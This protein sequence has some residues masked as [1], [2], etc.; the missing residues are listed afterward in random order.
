[1]CFHVYIK[2]EGISLSSFIWQIKFSVKTNSRRSKK[3]M[4][5]ITWIF[6]VLIGFSWRVVVGDDEGESPIDSIVEEKQSDFYFAGELMTR[7]N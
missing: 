7:E 2:F 4:K 5:I 6:V 1:M 3:M